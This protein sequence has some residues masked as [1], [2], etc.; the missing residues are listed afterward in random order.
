M[1]NKLNN[2]NI[3]TIYRILY[4][5]DDIEEFKY[6]HIVNILTNSNPIRNG[7]QEFFKL[8]ILDLDV[9]KTIKK[10]LIKDEDIALLEK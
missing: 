3:E 6:S 4:F 8:S 9:S 7:Y 2:K 1:S 10:S 5:A